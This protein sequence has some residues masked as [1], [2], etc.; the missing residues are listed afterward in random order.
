MG[1]SFSFLH[2]PGLIRAPFYH[3]SSGAFLCGWERPWKSRLHFK[4]MNILGPKGTLCKQVRKSQVEIRGTFLAATR[5]GA[6]DSQ[7]RKAFMI[8]YWIND[9]EK[10]IVIPPMCAAL[11]CRCLMR[12][13]NFLTGWWWKKKKVPIFL[14]ENIFSGVLH[15]AD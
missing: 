5:I 8:A 15:F 7:E 11:W 3:H 14:S 4:G 6:I 2:C 12:P 10:S 13:G 1:K 9:E